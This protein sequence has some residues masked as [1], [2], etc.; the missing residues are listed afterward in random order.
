MAVAV[1]VAVAVAAATAVFIATY[2]KRKVKSVSFHLFPSY[3]VEVTFSRSE[4]SGPGLVR[5][6]KEEDHPLFSFSKVMKVF[7]NLLIS[8]LHQKLFNI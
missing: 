5:L 8:L 7:S 2:K 6:Q 4:P 1:A 3:K